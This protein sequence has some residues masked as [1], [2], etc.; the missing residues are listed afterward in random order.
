MRIG[1]LL[2][3][4][5]VIPL[6]G[7]SE[8]HTTRKAVIDSTLSTE[9]GLVDTKGPM[10]STISF[11]PKT[12]QTQGV[13]KPI[14]ESNHEVISQQKDQESLHLLWKEVDGDTLEYSTSFRVGTFSSRK[15]LQRLPYPIELEPGTEQFLIETKFITSTDPQI[16]LLAAELTE[17]ITDSVEA[18]F[19]IAHWVRDNIEYNLSTLTADISRDAKWVLNERTGVCDEL[20]VLFLA[21]TRAAGIPSRYVTGVA[22][23]SSSDFNTEWIPHAWA[24][25]YVG[26]W[27][28]F[29]LTY[30]QFGWVD[31]SHI[32]MKTSG[33]I[34]DPSITYTWQDGE[35]ELGEV[36]FDAEIIE[37][38]PINITPLHMRVAPLARYVYPGGVIP[39]VVTVKN[40][41]DMRIP[42]TVKVKRTPGLLGPP[43][44]PVLVEPKGEVDLFYFIALPDRIDASY[45][46][47]APFVVE[48]SYGARAITSLEFS[49]SYGQVTEKQARKMIENYKRGVAESTS[50]NEKIYCALDKG[51]YKKGEDGLV[52]C[53]VMEGDLVCME[54]KCKEADGNTVQFS[55]IANETK[56]LRIV[57]TCPKGNTV[58]YQHVSVGGESE[59]VVHAQCPAWIDADQIGTV[60]VGLE[61]EEEVQDVF[62]LVEGTEAKQLEDFKGRQQAQI[63]VVGR[64]LVN[65]VGETIIYVQYSDLD[66]V[67][68]ET[69]TSCPIR[70]GEINFYDMIVGWWQGV[71]NLFGANN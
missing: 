52:L 31:A 66:G 64:D 45:D 3:V 32:V 40:P 29:D 62:V 7:A 20:T 58:M 13:E 17:N 11:F 67:R 9:V 6:V 35:I 28:P 57:S 16:R 18:T 47:S 70:I 25:V 54:D 38:T 21:L 60:T 27:I 34:D 33:N 4:L 26:E 12:L 14:V 53:E 68:Y 51:F 39:V 42:S 71:L 10:T 46:Y 63:Q 61:S 43:T 5:L 50:M 1:I 8:F 30:G 69:Y 49:T 24:E 44:Q 59:M 22:H 55:F 65:N 36:M 2:I 48:D 37:Q 56:D 23:T 41:T 19:A 15:D